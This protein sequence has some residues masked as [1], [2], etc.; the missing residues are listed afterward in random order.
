[1]LARTLALIAVKAE[2]ASRLSAKG[3]P[4]ASAELSD[5][6]R[7]AGQAVRDVR[8]AVSASA[9][10]SLEAE[11]AAAAIALRAAGI[12]ASLER[13]G[14]DVDPAHESALAWAVREAVTNV[15][16]HSGARTCWIRLNARSGLLCGRAWSG[17]SAPP[18]IWQRR[19]QPTRQSRYRGAD[20][21]C[22][23]QRQPPERRR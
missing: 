19:R 23:L 12:Q 13:N 5:V 14:S 21:W 9:S 10:P 6:Q 20:G 8:E 4:G 22:R 7:L 18:S 15:V 2:L 3:D 16:K 17:Y 1:V 11:L